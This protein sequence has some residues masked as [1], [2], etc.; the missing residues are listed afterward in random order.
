MEKIHNEAACLYKPHPTWPS[1]ASFRVNNKQQFIIVSLSL[2][3]NLLFLEIY[4][5]FYY[6]FFAAIPCLW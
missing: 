6:F 3:A 2:R 1:V 5:L 4:L